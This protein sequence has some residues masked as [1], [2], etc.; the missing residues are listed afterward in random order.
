[1]AAIQFYETTAC[2]QEQIRIRKLGF[3]TLGS[4]VKIILLKKSK[5]IEGFVNVHVFFTVI[6]FHFLLIQKTNIKL[7]RLWNIKFIKLCETN[8][9][10]YRFHSPLHMKF[11][12]TRA[13]YFDFFCKLNLHR[14][15]LCILSRCY[16]QTQTLSAFYFLRE[17]GYSSELLQ[18][19]QTPLRICRQFPLPKTLRKKRR[20]AMLLRG[21]NFPRAAKKNPTR[22]NISRILDAESFEG[23]PI[24][25][26]YYFNCFF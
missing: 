3:R 17:L 23:F 14:N 25:N 22:C 2:H 26:W 13:Q 9:I 7:P 19:Q 10:L 21:E 16:M 11:A 4:R 20:W 15:V 12:Y 18:Q 6:H 24:N 5:S 1:M 8:Y